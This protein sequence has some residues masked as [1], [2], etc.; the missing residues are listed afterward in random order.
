MARLYEGMQKAYDDVATHY[1]GYSCKGCTDN[2]CTQRFFHH[3]ISEYRYLKEGLMEALR[4]DPGLV[5]QIL[6]KA[7]VV[8]DTY[9][10]EMETGEILPLMCPANAD[11]LCMLYSHRPMIC[12]LHGLPHRFRRPD[13]REERGGG[14]ARFEGSHKTDWTVNR[15]NLYMDLA[16]VEADVRRTSGFRGRYSLTTAEMFMDMLGEEPELQ[17]LLADEE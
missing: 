12:R 9:L 4:S 1:D 14:C 16:A 11:G 2:C 5:R 10:N 17:A 13:G 7:R 15:S 8:V 3:T 6:I